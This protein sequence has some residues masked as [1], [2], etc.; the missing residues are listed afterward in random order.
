MALQSWGRH[1][2]R[3]GSQAD[4]RAAGAPKGST[5]VTFVFRRIMEPTNRAPILRPANPG[6]DRAEV[7]ANAL[8]IDGAGVRR[9]QR[10]TR[11]RVRAP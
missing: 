5:N 10:Q 8:N 4:A 11:V 1:C 6:R 3:H 9:Q 2:A 7:M